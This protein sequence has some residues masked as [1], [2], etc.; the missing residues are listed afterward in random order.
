MATKT[1]ESVLSAEKVALEKVQ[2]ANIKAEENIL[3]GKKKARSII[4][5][6]YKESEEI[7]VQIMKENDDNITELDKKN[8]IK[9][10]EEINNIYK[11]VQDKREKAINIV[12]DTLFN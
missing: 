5:N 10:N 12:I 2:D 7:S 9:Y 11:G 1:I 3:L 4:E 6:A 8:R